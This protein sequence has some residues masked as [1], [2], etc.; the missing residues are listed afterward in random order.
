[1]FDWDDYLSSESDCESWP[2]SSLYD[3]F[4]PSGGYHAV[5]PPT[6]G[7]FMPPKPDL[8]ESETKASQIVPSF[9]QSS[10]QVKTPR[11][12]IQPV[13]TSIPAATPKPACPKSNS[14]GKRRNKKVCFVCKSV[15]HLIKDCDYHAKK[16]AQPTPRNYAH[17][18]LTQSKSVSITA[19]RPVSAVVPKIMVDML[20]LEVTPRVVRFLENEELRQ[21]SDESQVLLRVPREKNMYTINLKNI[22]PSEDLTCLFVKATIDESNL[23]HR[24]L[25]HINFKTINKLVK[26]EKL[27]Q[28][29][30]QQE[31]LKAVKARLNFEEASWYSESEMPSRRRNLK[32]KLGPRYARTRSGSPKPRRAHSKSQREKDPKRRT[33]FKRLEKVYFIGLETRRIMCPLIQEAWSESHTTVAA[34]TLKAV[35]KVLA[36]KKQKLL[37]KTSS[38]KSVFAKNESSVIKHPEVPNTMIKL[39]LFPFSLEGEARTWLDKEPPCSILTWEDLVSKFINQFFP[40]SKKTYLRNEIINFL[41]KSN[42]TFNE[43]WERFKNILRKSPHHGFSELHQLDTFYNAL[44]PN[45]QDALDSAAVGNFLGKIPRDGLAIIESKSKV[46]YSRSRVTDSRV[47]TNAPFLSFSPCNSFELQQITASLEDKLDIRMSHFEKSLN[48]IKAL[49][50][51]PPAPIKAVEEMCFTCGANHSYNHCPLTRGGNE[52]PIFHDNIQQFQT[53]AVGNF[54]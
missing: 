6:T 28:E 36:L 17:R 35:T 44:N 1:M 15:D 54:V 20:P 13:E 37:R 18:V 52:I 53:A 10:E 49:V 19:V 40:P 26:A 42:E 5:P 29:K 9:V 50:V 11:L 8:D 22:V 14:S 24:R 3:R 27:H 41:Q 25:A 48:D 46:R 16:M 21:L 39:L 23:W 12:S 32:E 38:Q 7:T 43:A 4:Q 47:S 2:P 34:G 45:D 33:V 30:A 51:T 31:K